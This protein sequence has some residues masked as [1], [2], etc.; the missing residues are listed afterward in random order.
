M[1][2]DE[3]VKLDCRT[4]HEIKMHDPS[5]KEENILYHI[6]TVESGGSKDTSAFIRTWLHLFVRM[7]KKLFTTLGMKYFNSKGMTLDM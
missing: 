6:F 5:V 4:T 7:H 1:N 3:L 2:K